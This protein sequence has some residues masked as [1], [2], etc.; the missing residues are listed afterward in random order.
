MKPRL[1]MT[2]EMVM[3]SDIESED[4]LYMN[5]RK[6]TYITCSYDYLPASTG[7]TVTT[8]NNIYMLENEG[9][10]YDN[11]AI[12]KY[13]HAEN[14]WGHD[15]MSAVS[16]FPNEGAGF[17]V[18]V[19]RILYYVST[20]RGEDIG[21][22]RIRK[23]NRHAD[24]WQECSQLQLDIA[25]DESLALSCG[26]HLYF[27]MRSVMHCYDPSQNCWCDC[28]PPNLTA[29]F[30]HFTAVAIGTEIFC[31]AFQFTQT[32]VYDTQSDC[33]Q[34][35]QGWTNPEALSVSHLP[36]LFVLENQL[37]I[38]LKVYGKHGTCNYLVYVYDRS[39]DAWRDLKATLPNKE[40]YAPAPMCPVARIYVPYLKGAQK[41]ITSY[42][43]QV[44]LQDKNA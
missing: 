44:N 37:H 11:L 10:D 8:D 26:T 29:R 9:E 33:W 28:T 36:S 4:L 18:E 6:G 12:F 30:S 16:E 5:P 38:L 43:F 40:Y 24:Q 1:G 13:N 14:M 20:D 7:M 21:L 42:A 2:T 39:A 17:L 15:G 22:V 25:V 31:T 34:K 19:D 3:L 27:I 41:H 23:Y 35:L 32:M